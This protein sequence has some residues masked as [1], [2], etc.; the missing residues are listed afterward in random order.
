MTEAEMQIIEEFVRT[1]DTGLPI[2]S[3]RTYENPLKGPHFAKYLTEVIYQRDVNSEEHRMVRNSLEI[4]RI[5]N[6]AMR[7]A[8]REKFGKDAMD[9]ASEMESGDRKNPLG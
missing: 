2:K 5:L 1:I 9:G 4:L 6:Q 7:E 3:I 8:R